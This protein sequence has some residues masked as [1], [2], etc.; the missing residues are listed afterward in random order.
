[1]KTILQSI[2]SDGNKKKAANW[3]LSYY[4]EK[5]K[6]E[7]VAV[8]EE[9]GYPIMIKKMSASMAAAMW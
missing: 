6:E 2:S 7:F 4:G 1:M 3:I 9:L 8:C 5:Y